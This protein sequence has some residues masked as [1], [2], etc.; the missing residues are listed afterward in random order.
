GSDGAGGDRR[1]RL[2]T[3]S[4]PRSLRTRS[5]HPH[6]VARRRGV[7]RTRPSDLTT[8]P[9]GLIVSA[10]LA[11]Q[12]SRSTFP[13]RKPTGSTLSIFELGSVILTID[14]SRSMDLTSA[15]HTTGRASYRG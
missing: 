8:C 10:V 4:A 5:R 6:R 9:A 15:E 2:P 3:E 11:T 1:A 13:L 14:P 7:R 12:R